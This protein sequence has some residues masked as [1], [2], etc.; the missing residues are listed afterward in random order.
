M[1]LAVWATAAAA[2]SSPGA[3]FRL[4]VGQYTKVGDL[5]VGFGKVAS[6]GRCPIGVVCVW[7]GN[8]ECEMW[9]ELPGSGP[10]EFTLHTSPMFAQVFIYQGYEIRLLLLEPY[11]V[12]QDPP[13]HDS[14][15]AT[16]VVG[17]PTAVELST[18]GRIK[19]LYVR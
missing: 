17:A 12:Y 5:V 13:P 19:S 8:A 1:L 9:A 11:P 3:P 4:P 16:L 15:V 14:Y 10:V 2:D 18:W 6:D 7:E